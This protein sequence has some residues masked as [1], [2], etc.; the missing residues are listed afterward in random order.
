[1][2]KL[3][4]DQKARVMQLK[5]TVENYKKD[6]KKTKAEPRYYEKKLQKLEKWW[7]E[8]DKC[9]TDILHIKENEPDGE[10]QPYFESAT[11]EKTRELYIKHRTQLQEKINEIPTTSAARIANVNDKDNNEDIANLLASSESDTESDSDHSDSETRNEIGDTTPAEIKVLHFQL[12]EVQ[13]AFTVAENL[14]AG[15]SMGLANAQ[16]DNIKI[17]WTEF[18]SA[19][20]TIS[21]T[22][23]SDYCKRIKFNHLQQK[24]IEICGKLNDVAHA[25]KNIK[26]NIV[27]PKINLPEF[28]GKS[29]KWREFKD[30]FDAMVH[31]EMSYE[32]ATKMHLLKTCVKG[33]AAKLVSHLAPTEANYQICYEILCNRYENKREIV[34][35][36]IDD[37][38]KLPKQRKETGEGLK[39]IH[40]T[41]YECVMSIENIGVSTNN[42][43]TLLIHVLL[44]KLDSKTIMDYEGKLADVKDVQT[45][46]YFL[47]Y[48]EKRFLS[49]ISAERKSEVQSDKKFEKEKVEMPFTCTYCD[50]SHSIYRCNE[51]MKLDPEKRN[52]W[53]KSKKAC[54]VCLQF[55]KY[56]ECKSKFM[57]KKCEKKHNTLLHFESKKTSETKMT[58]NGAKSAFCA[59]TNEKIDEPSTSGQFNALVASK[60]NQTLLATA[61]IRVVSKN[62]EKVLLRALVDQGAQC[63]F[64]TE[65]ALQ[66]L[67]VPTLKINAKIGGIGM[68]KKE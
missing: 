21:T 46:K 55:H 11:Y 13:T 1:M 52:D 33:D 59:T 67:R 8:F 37:I 26:T 34:S 28:D 17:V 42:W 64:L 62:G 2:E 18:R 23:N 27:L 31:R 36:L 10:Q 57:C 58:P 9:H 20:R 38:L 30:L 14:Q 15:T 19:Y 47:N 48:I 40:D 24:Y 25:K 53:A 63:A 7:L 3:L 65:N 66:L 39:Q 51:F 60:K 16:L 56:G 41:T 44:K 32:N 35:N 5:K 68:A 29:S 6:S 49:L 12:N 4:Q 61:L 45:L 54:F 43:D 22:T 50:K